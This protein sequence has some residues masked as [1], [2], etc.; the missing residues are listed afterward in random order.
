MNQTLPE[1]IVYTCQNCR[2]TYKSK[3]G[4]AYHQKKIPCAYVVNP[5]LRAQ[6][7]PY[8]GPSSSSNLRV[9][10]INDDDWAD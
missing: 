2:K 7:A 3:A 6:L 5:N 8:M 1:R 10:N 4:L 9:I